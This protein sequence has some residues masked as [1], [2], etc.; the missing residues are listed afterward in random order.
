MEMTGLD[1]VACVPLQAALVVTTPD[2][3][4]LE[5]M[6]ITIWQPESK[7]ETIEPFV[8]KMHTDN[9]LLAKVRTSE[10]AMLEAERKLL[11]FVTRHFK[12]G[13]A[14]LCGNSIHQD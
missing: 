13:E 1:P 5:H 3:I 4:E 10:L 14:V 12:A 11:Q 9:G 8:R 6:E 2:L 7:L